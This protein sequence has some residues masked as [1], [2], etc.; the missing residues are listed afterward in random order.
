MKKI[1]K[2]ELKKNGCVK[3]QLNIIIYRIR[4]YFHLIFQFFS[5]S[6]LILTD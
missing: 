2:V 5:I 3:H 6:I 4:T 1:L